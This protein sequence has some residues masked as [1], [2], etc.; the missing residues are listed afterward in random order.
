MQALGI[1]QEKLGK[2][3]ACTRGAV[4]HYLSGRRSPT[5][6]QLSIIAAELRLNVCWLV[7]GGSKV[8]E[9]RPRYEAS[10]KA[11]CSVPVEGTTT[12]RAKSTK[13][14]DRLILDLDE[15]Y[16]LTV[17]SEAWA[18]RYAKGEVLLI[19]PSTAPLPGS[20]LWVLYRDGSQDLLKLV[21]KERQRV[22]FERLAEPGE[23]RISP[24]SD[25]ESMHCVLGVVRRA[26]KA[27]RTRK[28]K[29]AKKK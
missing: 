15:A 9:A 5:L 4:G 16:A 18:P 12:K 21:R 11:P 13:T 23:K 28:K 10:S 26:A 24:N 19:S 27:G 17:D 2:A 7:F 8:R 6:D 22:I 25:I 29:A 14:V 20:E 3:L 1:S